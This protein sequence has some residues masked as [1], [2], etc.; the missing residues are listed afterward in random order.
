MDSLIIFMENQNKK[1]LILFSGGLDS[2]VAAKMMEEQGF[3]VHLAFVKLPFGGGCGTPMAGV[4]EFAESQNFKLHI[5]DA[6][7]GD[8]FLEYVNIIKNP[9]FGTGS[10]INP[11]KDCKIFIFIEGAKLAKE[12]GA[13]VIVT[14]EVQ[15]QRPMSQKKNTML[16]DDEVAGLTGKILRPLSAKL[17]PETEYEKSGIVDREK[18]LDIEGRRREVQMKMADKYNIKYPGSGGGCVLCE[19]EYSKR[20][21]A[22]YEYRGDETPSY[23]E[24]LF[25]KRGRMYKASG[26]LFVGRNY[27]ENV[28]LEKIATDLKWNIDKNEVTPGPTVVYDKSED[29]ELAEE[30]RIAFAQKDLAQRAKFNEYKI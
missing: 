26:L 16:F 17:L 24:I 13:E 1:A 28:L 29:S 19:K 14:G 9:K 10:G 21:K 30:L 7:E 23:Q 3:E 8:K 25:L 15:G 22:L 12:L 4:L 18:L 11:C 2:R 20:L 6:T 27:E 5:I